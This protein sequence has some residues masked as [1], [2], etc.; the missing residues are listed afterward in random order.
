MEEQ[1]LPLMISVTSGVEIEIQ[2]YFHFLLFNTGLKTQEAGDGHAAVFTR[3]HC[4]K[5]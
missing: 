5:D 4:H 3:L 2:L 1:M